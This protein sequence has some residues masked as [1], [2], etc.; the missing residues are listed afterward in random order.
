MSGPTI[1]IGL[2]ARGLKDKDFVS[3]S[4]PYVTVSRPDTRG[5]FIVLRTSE[6][7]KNTLNPDWNDFL[8][9][10]SELNGND[11]ELNLRIEVFDDDGKKGPDRKDKL[12]GSGFYSLKQ[13]EA[14][15]LVK[16]M[17]PLSDGKRQ[18]AAGQLLVRSFKE[19]KGRPDNSAGVY[20]AGSGYSRQNQA[21]PGAG[22][23]GYPSHGATGGAGYPSYP[24]QP[25][26]QP[27]AYPAGPGYPQGGGGYP[28]AGAGFPQV[29]GGYPQVGGGYPQG[30][31]Y[32]QGG[33]GYP[34]VSGGYPQGGG[35][36][37]QGGGGYPQGGGGYPQGGGI[38][39]QGSAHNPMY[40]PSNLPTGPAGGFFNP[41]P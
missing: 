34:Q 5:G 27:G 29:A 28:Q 4:D 20:G 10:E 14:A 22:P 31:A 36:Y 39:P 19:H 21:P 23:A 41:N 13:L 2:G 33:G 16:S 24:P 11:K 35:G 38:Y 37:P 1:S 15:A 40:P 17:L 3:V 30:P 8:F 9:I 25:G 12:L 18:K 26:P 6:T 7:K 32:P